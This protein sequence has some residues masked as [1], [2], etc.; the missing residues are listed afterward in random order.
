[1]S[2]SYTRSAETDHYQILSSNMPYDENEVAI[3]SSL[4]KGALDIDSTQITSK[5]LNNNYVDTSA[6]TCY[7]A[8]IITKQSVI[9]VENPTAP[10]EYDSYSAEVAGQTKEFKLL[11]NSLVLYDTTVAVNLS[12]PEEFYNGV[13]GTVG[14]VLAWKLKLDTTDT[15]FVDQYAVNT[16]VNTKQIITVDS[17]TTTN[18][19]ISDPIYVRQDTDFNLNYAYGGKVTGDSYTSSWGS[20]NTATG[21]LNITAFPE[22][23][24]PK[25]MNLIVKQRTDYTTFDAVDEVGLYRISQDLSN[26]VSVTVNL[27]GI[28]HIAS[29]E[30]LTDLPI[31]VR[32]GVFNNNMKYLPPS[33]FTHNDFIGLF[34]SS[35]ANTVREN[36]LFNINISSNA[37]NNAGYH[38]SDSTTP[39]L[40]A[41]DNSDLRDNSSY[42]NNYLSDPH[43][44]EISKGEVTID[45]TLNNYVTVDFNS[46]EKL[47]EMHASQNGQI[48][49]NTNNSTERTKNQTFTNMQYMNS[50]DIIVQYGSNGINN[51][52]MSNPYVNIKCKK[53]ASKESNEASENKLVSNNGA[54]L[55]M[56]TNSVVTSI[57]ATG[58]QLNSSLQ[59]SPVKNELVLLKVKADSVL[60]SGPNTLFGGYNETENKGTD[61]VP[62]FAVDGTLSN[63]L[64]NDLSY[65]S[66][67]AKLTAKTLDTLSLYTSVNSTPG[68]NIKY[69]GSTDTYLTS[70]AITA[71]KNGESI[72]YSDTLI[73]RVNSGEQLNYMYSYKTQ[74]SSHNFGGLA[75]FVELSFW[76][77]S[78]KSDAITVTIPQAHLTRSYTSVSRPEV[79][80][81]GAP[82]IWT[83]L[84]GTYTPDKQWN[85]Q[86]VRQ[87]STYNVSFN[88]NYSIFNNIKLEI[89]GIVQ[90]NTYYTLVN[91]GTD[92]VA[93]HSSLQYISAPTITDLYNIKEVI[94][95]ST[96]MSEISLEGIMN[97]RDLRGFSGIVEG[98]NASSGLWVEV[99]NRSDID[100][101]YG[102]SDSY[103]LIGIDDDGME[104][105]VTFKNVYDA[106][107]IL[108]N[109]VAIAGQLTK[110]HYYVPFSARVSDVD[111]SVSSFTTKLENLTQNTNVN[112]DNDSYFTVT[113]GYS[114]IKNWSTSQGFSVTTRKYPGITQ[115]RVRYTVPGYNFE[116]VTFVIPEGTVFRGDYIITYIPNDVWLTRTLI[117][118]SATSYSATQNCEYNTIVSNRLNLSSLKGI[119][120]NNTGLNAALKNSKIEF[121]LK[122]DYATVNLVGNAAYAGGNSE[123]NIINPNTN[124]QYTDEDKYSAIV[125]F[126]YYRGYPGFGINSYT[127]N[128]SASSVKFIV[129]GGDKSN[130]S[131]TLTSC[132]YYN[133]ELVV[134][135]LKDDANMSYANLG[136]KTKALFSITPTGEKQ[137]LPVTIIGDTA[138]V[139]ISNL[140]YSGS[141]VSVPVGGDATPITDVRQYQMSVNL[142]D[143]PD[144]NNFFTFSGNDKLSLMPSRVRLNTTNFNKTSVDYSIQY[145]PKSMY[146]HKV[147]PVE[148][149]AEWL[150]NPVLFG[151]N[152]NNVEPNE[153][154]WEHKATMSTYAA[155][156]QGIKLGQVEVALDPTKIVAGGVAYIAILP[157]QHHFNAVSYI[158]LPTPYETD[159]IPATNTVRKYVQFFENTPEYNP[160]SARPIRDMHGIEHVIAASIGVNNM[161]FTRVESI[162]A[163][164]LFQAPKSQLVSITV[165][166]PNMSVKMYTGL[167]NT[168]SNERIVYNGPINKMPTTFDIQQSHMVMRGRD[169]DGSIVFSIAP[170]TSHLGSMESIQSYEELYNTTNYSIYYNLNFSIGDLAFFDRDRTSFIFTAASSIGQSR[171]TLYTVVDLNNPETKLSYRRVYK[172]THISNINFDNLSTKST[173]SL[174]F[175]EGRSYYDTVVAHPSGLSNNPNAIWDYS[176]LLQNT[177]VTEPITWIRDNDFSDNVYVSWAYGNS[178]TSANMQNELFLIKSTIRKW[179]Y[180]Q[181]DPFLTFS[182]QYGLT[183]SEVSWDGSVY[184]PMVSTQV[185]IM[186]KPLSFPALSGVNYQIEQYSTAT[187]NET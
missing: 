163:A 69:S 159:K 106:M 139:S 71:Y 47:S 5:I 169:D 170:Y 174:S 12:Y 88:P 148:G 117:G 150:G 27:D 178:N 92:E 98:R 118:D 21:A 70:D 144:K 123:S 162:S 3:T 35:I 171:P 187:L 100:L 180:L 80:P 49:I 24:Q 13:L 42:M 77:N 63:L 15:S 66:Y 79:M 153:E 101:Y 173:L 102:L 51:D 68:W 72:M 73:Q 58:F 108:T 18:F 7:P 149:R 16:Y 91:S 95:S 164:S 40:D 36:Y 52:M 126:K 134:D 175:N 1:M 185:I 84:R 125:K 99:S 121:E 183:V 131:Q 17:Q 96:N 129:D 90:E 48:S 128:R 168:T 145:N 54:F 32:S 179:V 23:Y 31:S 60:V 110:L 10:P 76:F 11:S 140:S 142:A 81:A 85:L 122:S 105:D 127:I 86:K 4:V 39:V 103:E 132:M 151:D 155:K 181:L 34:N 44:F 94:K 137:N 45:N 38:L 41:I 26:A 114:C 65:N 67:R 177:N 55:T 29:E 82:Y 22:I 83:P 176:N 89:T 56:Y 115:V 64:K 138:T 104:A 136:I 156:A 111:Y 172:Y 19:E 119:S 57:P 124:Y 120:V 152:V 78:D 135:D 25:S 46:G 147:R 143:A 161:T 109:S 133:Q 107:N 116:L 28:S 141:V 61:V 158:D 9:A 167:N 93:P 8:G 182:N 97:A 2:T 43:S 75:D 160:F 113:N 50:S 130:L 87:V 74:Q 59:N 53:V 157:G 14:N 184:T 146:V 186:N 33:S 20:I 37:D 112:I 166:S 154:T 6:I 62:G 165:P 30:L